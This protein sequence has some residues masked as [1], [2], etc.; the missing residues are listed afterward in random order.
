MNAFWNLIYPWRDLYVGSVATFT[1]FSICS[2]YYINSVFL[3]LLLDVREYM[4]K[5]GLTWYLEM[6]ESVQLQC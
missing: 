6:L 4:E 3:G 2:L 1:V 5:S